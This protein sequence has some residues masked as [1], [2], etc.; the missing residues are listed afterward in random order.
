MPVGV[1][2]PLPEGDDVEFWARCARHELAVQRCSQCG[3]HRHPPRPRCARCHGEEWAWVASTGTGSVY[4]FTVCHP[5]V[6]PAFESEVPY[7]VVVV[8][9]EEGP[10]IVSNVVGCT[11]DE[12]R[13]G[14]PVEVTFTDVDE[15]LTLPHFRP[16][17][18]GGEA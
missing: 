18:P 15:S 13:V 5:P 6:L 3:L 8:Q 7:N 14:M 12:L 17:A 16:R 11:N 2:R 10:F 1:P 9:L 4:S